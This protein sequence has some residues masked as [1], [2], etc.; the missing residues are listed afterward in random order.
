MIGTV[1]YRFASEVLGSCKDLATE[2]LSPLLDMRSF[3]DSSDVNPQDRNRQQ[4]RSLIAATYSHIF[5]KHVIPRQILLNAVKSLNDHVLKYYEFD[6]IDSFLQANYIEVPSSFAYISS[7]VGYE[8]NEIGESS[9]R[10]IDIDSDFMDIN[11]PFNRIGWS[12]V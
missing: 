5:V 1:N 6:N 3:L 11:L 10:F 7:L 8:I 2:A 4:L 9:A 12:N